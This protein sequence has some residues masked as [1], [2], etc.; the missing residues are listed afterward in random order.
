MTTVLVQ[1]KFRL[2]GRLAAGTAKTFGL[3]TVLAFAVA[4]IA[5]L[6]YR[7][8]TGSYVEFANYVLLCLPLVLAAAAWIQVHR[9]YPKA[10]ADGATPKEFLTSLALYG[11]I[12]VVAAVA[13]VHLGSFVISLGSTFR[14][15]G[16]H[17]GFYGTGPWS[18]IVRATLYL[19][20]GAAAGTLSHRLAS[21]SIGFVLGAL[22]FAAV[23]YRQAWLWGNIAEPA[24]VESIED[25]AAVDAVLAVLLIL[26]TWALLARTPKRPKEI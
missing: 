4:A 12:A 23:G 16:H 18:S 19:A 11:I 5:S 7:E 17:E 14:G 20:L 3:G 9:T 21:R 22:L 13:F 2:T 6:V 8:T 24:H 15:V 26:A 25:F 10:L 1:S